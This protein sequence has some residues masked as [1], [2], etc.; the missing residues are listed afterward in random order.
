MGRRTERE[1]GERERK[2]E[3]EE[4]RGRWGRRGKEGALMFYGVW[5]LVA[6]CACVCV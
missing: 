2:G 5:Y 4:Y 3:R 6:G 1:R